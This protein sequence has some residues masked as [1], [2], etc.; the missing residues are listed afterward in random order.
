MGKWRKTIFHVDWVAQ[1]LFHE[2]IFNLVKAVEYCFDKKNSVK[3]I[4]PIKI[5]RRRCYFDD[6]D[7]EWLSDYVLHLRDIFLSDGPCF[8]HLT[9]HSNHFNKTGI[10]LKRGL[11]E[12]DDTPINQAHRARLFYTSDS[13]DCRESRQTKAERAR[14]QVKRAKFMCYR[15][16]FQ[17]DSCGKAS[18]I[19][20]H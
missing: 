10:M 17:S 1:Y 3:T 20:H 11:R 14:T 5:F 6:N 12:L 8:H 19:I 9:H 18:Q 15:W 13:R 16:S 4:E 7:L 2:F